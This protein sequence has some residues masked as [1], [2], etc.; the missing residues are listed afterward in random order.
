MNNSILSLMV[1]WAN[2]S[3]QISLVHDS[4]VLRAHLVSGT[5]PM[6]RNNLILVIGLNLLPNS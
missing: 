4:L 3:Y 5:I 6:K 1:Q 2:G